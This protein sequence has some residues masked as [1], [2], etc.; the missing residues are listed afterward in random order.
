M[1]LLQLCAWLLDNEGSF[2]PKVTDGDTTGAITKKETIRGYVQNEIHAY[3]Q[4]P[5]S[6]GKFIMSRSLIEPL[7]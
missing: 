1:A 4:V 3:L 5:A 7:V 6:T 2:K